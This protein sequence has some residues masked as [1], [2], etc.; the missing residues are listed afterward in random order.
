MRLQTETFTERS[1]YRESFYTRKLS[2]TDVFT[3]RI[4]YTEKLL[5]A[6]TFSHRS[7]YTE[8]PL[9]RGAFTHKGVFSQKLLHTDAATQRSLHTESFNTQA[10]LQTETF[11]QRSLYRESFYTRKLSHTEVFTQRSLYTEKLLHT[12]AF[13]HRSFYTSAGAFGNTPS[14]LAPIK[15]RSSMI[16]WI[17]SKKPKEYISEAAGPRS[18]AFK[19]TLRWHR[20]QVIRRSRRWAS[21]L[22]YPAMPR[23]MVVVAKHSFSYPGARRCRRPFRK[24][25]RVLGYSRGLGWE[26]RW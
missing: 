19:P 23:R 21:A 8:K 12:S 9:H 10:R 14:P 6:E 24:S 15:K 5:H 17:C 1:L 26:K 25:F 3:Q 18:I 4:L 11:T 20:G 22:K 7:F 13:T 2:H 16:P